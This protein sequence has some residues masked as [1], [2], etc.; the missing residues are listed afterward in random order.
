MP[1]PRATITRRIQWF[2]TDS[3]TKYHNTAPLRLMEEAEAALLDDLGIVTEVYGW[4]PRRHVTIEYY[5]PLRFWDQVEVTVEVAEV[6]TTSVTYTFRITR[7]GQV[8]ADGRVVAVHIDDRG[9][10]DPWSDRLRSL[11]EGEG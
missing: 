10:A 7:N 8:H 4:L 3:S 1:R 11:L 2:D 9:K 5:K 6:G